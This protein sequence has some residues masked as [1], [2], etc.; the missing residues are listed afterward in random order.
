VQAVP[1]AEVAAA[2]ASF[3]ADARGG[4]PRHAPSARAASS[5]PS[6]SS[7]GPASCRLRAA[8]GMP[9][10][11]AGWARRRPLLCLMCRRRPRPSAHARR[12]RAARAPRHAR[13]RRCPP[14]EAP[15]VRCS[16]C[17]GVARH[18]GR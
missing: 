12:C 8:M 1:P 15:A 9:C 6:A 3:L 16:R 13:C 14:P 5:A 17:G 10:P 2:R 11:H 18:A 4:A 7:C